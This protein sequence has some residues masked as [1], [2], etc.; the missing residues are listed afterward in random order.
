MAQAAAAGHAAAAAAEA[1]DH[2]AGDSG[3]G[4][5]TDSAQ[6]HCSR[7]NRLPPGCCAAELAS[8]VACSSWRR[9]GGYCSGTGTGGRAARSS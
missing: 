5:L 9:M 6:S 8:Q 4:A 1:E 2:G 7:L 3:A